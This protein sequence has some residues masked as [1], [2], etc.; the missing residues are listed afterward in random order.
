MGRDVGEEEKPPENM[1]FSLLWPCLSFLQPVVPSLWFRIP[2]AALTRRVSNR[3]PERGG[4]SESLC[5]HHHQ[6][7][8]MFLA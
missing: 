7:Y 6:E 1:L 4:E 8:S 3:G 2:G 5:I